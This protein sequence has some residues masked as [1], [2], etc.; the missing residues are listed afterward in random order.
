[1]FVSPPPIQEKLP[2][3]PPSI[4]Q[5][6][7][8][9]LAKDPQQRFANVQAFATA[10]EQACLAVQHLPIVSP[11]QP[12]EPTVAATPPTQ[13]VWPTIPAASLSRSPEPAVISTPSIQGERTKPSV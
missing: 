13:Q 6:V 12:L 10:L 2:T 4:E 8:I 9:A 5:V 1:L 7:M 3:I 11:G